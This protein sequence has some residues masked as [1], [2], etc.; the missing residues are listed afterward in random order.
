MSGLPEGVIGPLEAQAAED[1]LD[2]AMNS[3]N[4]VGFC[5][6]HL[7]WTAPGAWIVV[8][9]LASDV[10][11]AGPDHSVPAERHHPTPPP[12][13]VRDKITDALKST[14]LTVVP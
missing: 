12:I 1:A 13:D 5:K 11:L 3:D 4:Y 14:G 8:S 9:A 2:S 7:K 6:A 10:W